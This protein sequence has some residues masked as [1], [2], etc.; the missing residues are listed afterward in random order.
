MGSLYLKPEYPRREIFP[1]KHNRT[2]LGVAIETLEEE[3]VRGGVDFQFVGHA[4]DI[5]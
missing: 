3:D 1:R 2:S 5:V 4:A